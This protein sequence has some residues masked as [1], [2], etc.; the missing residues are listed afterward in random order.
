MANG[1]GLAQVDVRWRMQTYICGLDGAV[2]AGV[3]VR[4]FPNECEDWGTG[5]AGE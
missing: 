4:A 2:G 5:F 3:S 1:N